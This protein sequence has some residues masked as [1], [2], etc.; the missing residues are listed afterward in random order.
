[1]E[2][3]LRS[4]FSV[5][6][7]RG[8]VVLI[9]DFLDP[10]R[11]ET[12]FNLLRHFRHDVFAVHVVCREEMAPELPDEVIL[13]DSEEGK[14]EKIEVTPGVLASYVEHYEAHSQALDSYCRRYGW[15]YTRASTEVPFEDLI[16][17]VFRQNRFLR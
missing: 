11:L 9:S 10:H 6:R 13:V 7:R 3:A 5:R 12:G 15:G 16:L 4:F 1:L 17:Q 14:T 8:L 2:K